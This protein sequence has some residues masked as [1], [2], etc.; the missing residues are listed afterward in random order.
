MLSRSMWTFWVV[1]SETLDICHVF[2]SK[3]Y[4]CGQDLKYFW[5][6]RLKYFWWRRLLSNVGKSLGPGSSADLAGQVGARVLLCL[7]FDFLLCFRFDILASWFPP[8]FK[9]DFMLFDFLLV[10]FQFDFLLLTPFH[11]SGFVLFVCVLSSPHYQHM[12]MTNQYCRTFILVI[13]ACHVHM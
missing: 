4:F 12:K 11:C 2:S 6:R 9:I 8:C 1:I 13:A 7:H 10:F 5:L 3:K